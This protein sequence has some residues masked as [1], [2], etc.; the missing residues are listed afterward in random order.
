MNNT[1][2]N[3]I[4]SKVFETWKK[5]K[6]TKQ[7]EWFLV[8]SFGLVCFF[9]VVGNAFVV[10][11]FGFKRK[12]KLKFDW[13]IL[14]LGIVDF[15]SSLLNPP[16]FIYLT[17]NKYQ[18]WHFGELGCKIIPALGPIMSSISSGIL[19]IIAID[20]Y[21]A[22]VSNL[23][24]SSIQCGTIKVALMIDILLSICV[25]LHYIIG[26]KFERNKYNDGFYCKVPDVRYY[27]FSIPN[28]I[29]IIFR[30]V[31]FVVVFTFTNVEI[32]LKLRRCREQSFC[33]NLRLRHS[34]NSKSAVY[35]L[36]TMGV[37]FILLVFPKEIFHLVYSLSWMGSGNGIRHT[38]IIVEIN[39]W[40]KVLHTANSCANVFIYSQ[41]H[42]VYRKQ[43]I[44]LF[45]KNILKTDFFKLEK[46]LRK[47]STHLQ[48][49]TFF[50][51]LNSVTKK[52]ER[53]RKYFL[54]KI[55]K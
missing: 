1:T 33:K 34:K 29:L 31:V 46:N 41:M 53:R 55:N 16:L 17:F 13:L 23:K 54:N 27:N 30:F 28:C 52:V 2:I 49:K 44:K 36:T 10:Y 50:Q 35:V 21:L 40:L 51:S 48:N 45:K 9:G 3:I 32:Y 22:I 24:G 12:Y 15:F 47:L 20:R 7:S 4:I 18:Y 37:V 6:P 38:P 39:A 11:V 19:L 5:T 8:F 42:K 25:Y 26:L 14:C 43:M